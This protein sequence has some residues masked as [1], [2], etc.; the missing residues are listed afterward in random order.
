MYS[1]L[2]EEVHKVDKQKQKLVVLKKGEDRDFFC[3]VF[4]DV[5]DEDPE[6]TEL[7]KLLKL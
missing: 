5:Y 4:K 3:R 7:I 6:F 2:S 1:I